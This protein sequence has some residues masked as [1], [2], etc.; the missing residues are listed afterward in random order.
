[1]AL[2]VRAWTASET[3]AIS[4]SVFCC[5]VPSVGVTS[6]NLAILALISFQ[7]VFEQKPFLLL[8]YWNRGFEDRLD[9]SVI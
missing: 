8:W 6:N 1:M 3:A 9:R 5:T 7:G 2:G 4:L